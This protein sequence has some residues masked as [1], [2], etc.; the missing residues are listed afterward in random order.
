M[1]MRDYLVGEVTEEYGHGLLTRREALRRLGLLGVG[2]TAATAL[3]AA[4]GGGNSAKPVAT[5]APTPPQA[6]PPPGAD[7]PIRFSANGVDYRAAFKAPSGDPNGAVLIVHENKGL[8]THFYDL[9]RRFAA[10]GYTALCVDLLSR[11]G[12][13][14]TAGFTDQ[15]AA[16]GVLSRT[17]T[18][19]LVADLHAGADELLRRADVADLGVVGFCFGGGMAWNLLQAGPGQEKR[20]KVAVPFYGPAPAQPDFTGSKAAVLAIY[21]ALDARV[22]ASRDAIEQALGDAGLRH[23]IVTYPDADHAFYNDTGPRYNATAAAQATTKMFDWLD[24]YL[25]GQ[26][27][28]KEESDP[29]GNP[30]SASPLPVHTHDSGA[31]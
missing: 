21:G 23:E 2:V 10:R 27:P 14:G 13:D 28:P 6:T 3:L 5:A 30:G 29:G 16:T 25:A 19:Q 17:P 24:T 26:T 9:V 4:C 7:G 11:A 8:T 1:A 31:G 15:A 18:E 12:H 20:L 22:D